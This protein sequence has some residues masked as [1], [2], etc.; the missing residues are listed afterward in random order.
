[1]D[2]PHWPSSLGPDPEEI[3]PARFPPRSP[4]QAPGTG[5]APPPAGG[6]PLVVPSIPRT[7]EL[8]AVRRGDYRKG[9]S[10][11]MTALLFGVVTMVIAAATGY[12]VLHEGDGSGGASANRETDRQQRSDQAIREPRLRIGAPAELSGTTVV[13]A[14][15]MYSYPVPVA[16]DFE[17]NALFDGTAPGYETGV[18][19][20]DG[21][22][23][24][25]KYTLDESGGDG[26]GGKATRF[27]LRELSVADVEFMGRVAKVDE[28]TIDGRPAVVVYLEDVYGEDARAVVAY[29]AL[30]SRAQTVIR[31]E[32]TDEPQ[33]EDGLYEVASWQAVRGAC[34]AILSN[35]HI[36]V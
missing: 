32:G 18:S 9:S 30:D 33:G 11:A 24:V 36:G 17:V 8:V 25:K 15:G 7:A 21:S 16:G 29:I 27:A 28:R 31:V 5:A 22:V 14:D 23:V 35:L 2:S 10:K 13:A 19:S 6:P 12:L 4:E 20:I 26:G 1:M 3:P 34:E